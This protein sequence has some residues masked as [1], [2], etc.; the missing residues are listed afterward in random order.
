[1]NVN[2]LL[3]G[4]CAVMIGIA[5]CVVACAPSGRDA[6]V[7]FLRRGADLSV[8]PAGPQPVFVK[9]DSTGVPLPPSAAA[10]SMVQDNRTGLIWEVKTEA[11]GLHYNKASYTWDEART[12]FIDR[13]NRQRFGGASDWRLP[14]VRE[15][16]SLSDLTKHL[17]AID[18]DFFPNTYTHDY[19][20]ATPDAEDDAKAWRV[21]FCRGL[22]HA[23]AKSNRYYVRA[24][25]GPSAPAPSLT[26]NGDGTL[27]DTVTGLMWQKKY[28][29]PMTWLQALDYCRKL[30][31]GGRQDWRVPHAHELQTL[32]DYRRFNPAGDGDRLDLKAL[33]GEDP[34]I[35]PDH[36]MRRYMPDTRL[37]FWTST[38]YAS[39]LESVWVVD[40]KHGRL[41]HRPP[42]DRYY[43]RAVRGKLATGELPEIVLNQRS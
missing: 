33:K 19:W 3:G 26:E 4:M 34:G 17:P 7:K 38:V 23:M 21:H 43:V 40:F 15:L 22:V 39:S 37:G 32:V 9:L 41:W 31:T 2:K 12:G 8:R 24:V 42:E 13:L 10:W 27:T 36:P 11:E 1:M 6:S 28:Q 16:T 20:T 14:T 29:G 18:R 5:W 25:R 30:D 35:R